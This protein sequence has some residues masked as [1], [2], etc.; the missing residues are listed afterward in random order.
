MSRPLPLRA[1]ITTMVV[2]GGVLFAVLATSG[3]LSGA[4]YY[5][6]PSEVR[7]RRVDGDVIRVG[8]TVVT[9]SVEWA[10]ADGVLRFELSDGKAALPV[11]NRGAPPDLFRAGRD[12]LVEGRVEGGVLRSSDVIVKHDENYR[13]P[14][15]DG[16]EARR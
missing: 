14:G 7:E 10:A 4:V 8:G 15:P 5:Y 2:V 3:V 11:A 13:A 1:V 6:T 16:E 12:A 9:G